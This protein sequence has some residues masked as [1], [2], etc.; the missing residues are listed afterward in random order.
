MTCEYIG[1]QVTQTSMS[2]CKTERGTSHNMDWDFL[3]ESRDRNYSNLLLKT[4][5]E[6][7]EKRADLLVKVNEN[8]NVQIPTG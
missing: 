7:Q 5:R 1:T 4:V 6:M 2:M 3:E 8:I